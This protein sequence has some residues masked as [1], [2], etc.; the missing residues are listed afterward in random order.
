MWWPELLRTC[1]AFTLLIAAIAKFLEPRADFE[2]FLQSLTLSR[3]MSRVVAWSAPFL[4]I[5]AAGLL[6]TGPSSW[7]SAV[8]VPLT[9]AFVVVLGVSHSRG[10]SQSCRC[11]GAL[12]DSQTRTP[13]PLI[14]AATL[15]TM[16]I[17]V[18][19]AAA[20]RPPAV[21]AVH[22]DDLLLGVLAATVLIAFFTM[23][24]QVWAFEK[25]RAATLRRRTDT[26]ASHERTGS[27]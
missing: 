2:S 5:L 17:A 9:A 1:L 19:A 14:R 8:S 24:N 11:F 21:Q 12:D 27:R 18:A 13:V 25:F 26:I 4:E 7:A 15:A 23:L 22:S 20:W 10:I 6:L 16:A 3:T